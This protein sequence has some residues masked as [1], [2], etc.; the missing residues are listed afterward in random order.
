M[1]K[2]YVSATNAASELV[3]WAGKGLI[4]SGQLKGL[5]VP[6]SPQLML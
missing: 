1:H 4:T 2:A 6:G 3:P 5:P